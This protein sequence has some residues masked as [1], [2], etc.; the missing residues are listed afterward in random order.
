MKILYGAKTV[1]T[2]SAI[3]PQKVNR[4][5]WNLEHCAHIA[6]GWPWQ[7]L[8]AIR[9]VATIWEAAEIFVGQVNNARFHRFPMGQI[10][11]HSNTTNTTTW[12]V[13]AVKMFEYNLRLQAAITPQRLQIAGN[14]YESD[15]L[16]H[17]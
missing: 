13:E 7:I 4:F 11:R 10:L 1:F 12:I 6:G 9:A 8:G 15:P 2:R 5:G 16:W 17:I 14:Y 3:T